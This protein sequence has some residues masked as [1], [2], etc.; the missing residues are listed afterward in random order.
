MIKGFTVGGVHYKVIEVKN[1]TSLLR[2]EHYYGTCDKV[3]GLIEIANEL[4]GVKVNNDVKEITLLHEVLHSI[5]GIVNEKQELL[6][7]DEEERLVT[8]MSP[9]L[10]EFLSTRK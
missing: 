4:N 9:F 5:I 7:H 8:R 10:Y 3:Q 2:D 1:L 6:T